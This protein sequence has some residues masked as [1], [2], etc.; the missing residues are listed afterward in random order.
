MVEVRRR[1]HR[2]ILEREREEEVSS[3][4]REAVERG[5]GSEVS[6]KKRTRF[7]ITFLIFSLRKH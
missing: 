1:Y 7:Y 2:V 3:V 6:V 4:L 5:R